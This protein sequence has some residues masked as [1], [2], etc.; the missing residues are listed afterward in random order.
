VHA[1][2]RVGDRSLLSLSELG[3]LARARNLAACRSGRDEC[4]YSILSPSESAELAAAER[5]R[6]YQACLKGRGYCD[7]SRLTAQELSAIAEQ[8]AVAAP[9]AR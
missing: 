5:A 8:P 7:R 6:N 9:Q 2:L 1:G 4:D 3:E